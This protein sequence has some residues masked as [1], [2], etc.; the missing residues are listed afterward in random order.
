MSKMGGRVVEILVSVGFIR[1]SV[2]SFPC[3]SLTLK[4][5]KGILSVLDTCVNFILG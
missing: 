3:E 4:S 5:K 2:S 1:K